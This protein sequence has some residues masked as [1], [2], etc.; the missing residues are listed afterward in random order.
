MKV[1]STSADDEAELLAYRLACANRELYAIRSSSTWALAQRFQKLASHFRRLIRGRRSTQS[2]ALH[3]RKLGPEMQ[4]SLSI[5][6][7]V[8]PT[9]LILSLSV[10]P[11]EVLQHTLNLLNHQNSN[12]SDLR[13]TSHG[14]NAW[15][16]TWEPSTPIGDYH[17]EELA[18]RLA[19]FPDWVVTYD[20]DA[21]SGPDDSNRNPGTRTSIGHLLN[22]VREVRWLNSDGLTPSNQV[23]VVSTFTPTGRPLTAIINLLQSLRSA[24]ISAI[25]VDT[26]PNWVLGSHPDLARFASIYVR[27]SNVGWDF[28]SWIAVH[29]HPDLR[30]LIGDVSQLWWLNDS[31]YG[32]LTSMHEILHRADA[33]SHDVWGLTSSNQIK[34][35][36]QSYLLKFSRRALDA[37][38]IDKFI[39]EYPFPVVKSDII[40]EG[41]VRMTQVAKSLGLSVG[42][43]FA[44]EE[45]VEHYLSTWDARMS[46]LEQD[47]V[48]LAFK[49]AGNLSDCTRYMFHVVLRDSIENG[50]PHNAS[51][52]M[53][54][55]L[56]EMG[57]PM[58]KREL[59]MSNPQKVP[60]NTLP[61]GLASL[62]PTWKKIFDQERSIG[63]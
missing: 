44:Y 41:E 2:V 1:N 16:V 49:Q 25:V 47:P 15:S 54:D 63:E 60:I 62:S 29:T 19:G 40:L 36:L 42:A 50:V 33:E 8:G 61:D 59:V 6:P 9:D 46:R 22:S 56:L 24:G 18:V 28:S 23:A 57:F 10:G 17:P 4:M 20:A 39:H 32:P 13:V 7:D 45:V 53:W 14:A 21:R 35:H 43:G 48:V 58:I 11:T 37:G 26:S 51:H 34:P 38:L 5:A 27:R 52:M 12:D 31:C 55:S 30:G 3:V